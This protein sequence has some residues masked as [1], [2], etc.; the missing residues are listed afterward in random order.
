MNPDKP[1]YYGEERLK[2]IELASI[3]TSTFAKDDFEK[4]KETVLANLVE[5]KDTAICHEISFCRKTG[6][7][8]IKDTSDK[9]G[10]QAL[11]GEA[12]YHMRT[13]PHM[14]KNF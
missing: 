10:T 7:M 13:R 11:S 1:I 9:Q 12:C 5:V 3:K 2:Y 8:L 4:K 14:Q 6:A